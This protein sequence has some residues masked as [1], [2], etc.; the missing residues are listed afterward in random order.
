MFFTIPALHF[1]GHLFQEFPRLLLLSRKLAASTRPLWLSVFST[2][3]CA[4]QATAGGTGG[5][6]EHGT[7]LNTVFDQFR[8]MSEGT[9]SQ[10]PHQGASRMS[11]YTQL[12][13]K[14]NCLLPVRPAQGTRAWT[15]NEAAL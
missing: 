7:N 15:R 13:A 9:L 1:K 14:I 2:T 8:S 11:F 4:F 6:E 3:P 5:G 10:I 12:L